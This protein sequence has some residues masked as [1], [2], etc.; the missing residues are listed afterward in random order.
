[1]PDSHFIAWKPVS[2]SQAN[3]SGNWGFTVD[4][5]TALVSASN[6]VEVVA[7]KEV[8]FLQKTEFRK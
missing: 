5:D 8:V 1:L 2:I 7:N 4:K 3:S 6:A